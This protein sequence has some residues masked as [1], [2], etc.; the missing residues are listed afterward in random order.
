MKV[1]L[2]LPLNTFTFNVIFICLVVYKVLFLRSGTRFWKR[3]SCRGKICTWIFLGRRY[4]EKPDSHLH[5][6]LCEVNHAGYLHMMPKFVSRASWLRFRIL[7]FLFFFQDN[8]TLWWATAPICCRRLSSWCVNVMYRVY[9]CSW[10]CLFHHSAV[11]LKWSGVK[12]SEVKELDRAAS[13]HRPSVRPF[14]SSFPGRFV[15][16]ACL[17]CACGMAAEQKV[18]CLGALSRRT[19]PHPLLLS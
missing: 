15:N 4:T 13:T 7:L 19:H 9:I 14:R 16:S 10:R 17:L 2:R 8:W 18:C 11:I 5:E 3:G 1:I 6:A 12:W